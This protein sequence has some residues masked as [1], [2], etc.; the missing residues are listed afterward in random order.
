MIGIVD[1]GAGNLRS[2]KKAL[3]YL[4]V[5]TTILESADALDAI[6]GLVL[7]GVGSFGH[8]MRKIRESSFYEP[9]ERWLQSDKKFL[10]ICLGLQLLFETSEES[11][12]SAGFGYF[13]G[14]CRQ[15]RTEKVPQIGWNSITKRVESALLEGIAS[16]SFFYFN[17]S[18]YVEPHDV[19]DIMAITEYGVAYASI[20]GRGNVHAVQFH[21]EK[22][23]DVGIELLR[24]W[25]ERC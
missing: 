16:H 17:H 7:P 6:D 10:G 4:Q 11:P 19:Q 3:D 20:M 23:G 2:V 18:Y 13:P 24:N 22:S 8:A 21:P 25:L 9:I 5:E 1:Y 14:S 12:G 15:F